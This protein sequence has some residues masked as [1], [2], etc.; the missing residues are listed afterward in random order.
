MTLDLPALPMGARLPSNT[1]I[2]PLSIRQNPALAELL[3][4]PVAEE[5]ASSVWV[6]QRSLN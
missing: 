6:L 5:P 1:T 2:D 3:F 4:A